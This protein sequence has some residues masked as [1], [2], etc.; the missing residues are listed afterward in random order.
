LPISLKRSTQNLQLSTSWQADYPIFLGYSGREM[1]AVRLSHFD[2]N[3]WT[4][5]ALQEKTMSLE[6]TVLHN[7]SGL[8]LELML[9]TIME[10]RARPTLLPAMPRR[11]IWVISSRMR[12]KDHFSISSISLA[13][14]G[15]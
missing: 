1:L 10:I 9:R 12:W 7:V 8:V 14:L 4:H 3:V 6:R 13:D 15:G 5:R 11:A 2:P